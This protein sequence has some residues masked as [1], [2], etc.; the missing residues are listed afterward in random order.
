MPNYNVTLSATFKEKKYLITV[1]A[2]NGS[3]VLKHDDNILT[4]NKSKDGE[5]VK[6]Y[7]TPSTNYK[8]ESIRFS[9]NNIIIKKN[10]VNEYEFNMPA[11]DITLTASF[12]LDEETTEI[13]HLGYMP[14]SENI[15][16]ATCDNHYDS[17]SGIEIDL[18]YIDN[19][20]NNVDDSL[21]VIYCLEWHG[22]AVDAQ[23]GL[24]DFIETYLP[25]I[26]I[27]INYDSGNSMLFEDNNL[28]TV[29]DIG[30]NSQKAYMICRLFENNNS[31]HNEYHNIYG[32]QEFLLVDE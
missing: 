13:E 20:L 22:D 12:L 7:T 8:L 5:L 1:N 24:Q 25:G 6:I 2:E 4:D 23:T 18:W 26:Y 17:I 9:D 30:D 32:V 29:Y 27:R 14:T 10:G 16:Y 19:V 15:Y 3:V 31:F 11:K 28:T 21:V